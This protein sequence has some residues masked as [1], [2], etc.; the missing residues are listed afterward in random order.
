MI[1][2]HLK[3][4]FKNRCIHKYD[5]NKDIIKYIR[6]LEFNTNFIIQHEYEK[7]VKDL[8]I[9]ILYYVKLNKVQINRLYQIIYIIFLYDDFY[10]CAKQYKRNDIIQELNTI[11][12][13]LSEELIFPNDFNLH[14]EDYIKSLELEYLKVEKQNL[15]G[16]NYLRLKPRTM[17]T[18]L[19]YIYTMNI[20]L[21][22]FNYDLEF[23]LYLAEK[24]MTLV[25]DLF[26]FNKDKYAKNES[27]SLKDITE[28][29]IKE[30]IKENYDFMI[31]ID[32]KTDNNELVFALINGV[33]SW[34]FK[35]D[36][37]LD[38]KNF[39][40]KIKLNLNNEILQG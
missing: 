33:L 2:I 3:D 28:K 13:Y 20:D 31:K 40:S 37:Y 18:F 9:E 38:Y 24:D 8:I 19:T 10:I 15:L 35:T 6:N 34:S 29:E 1:T 32:K 30:K 11:R 25:N 17:G 4:I 39:N 22:Y 14:F 5:I 7:M 12:T 16:M 21:Q 26:S 36:R 23:L 27:N